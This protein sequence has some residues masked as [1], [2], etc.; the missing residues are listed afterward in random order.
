MLDD[1][2]SF[3]ARRPLFHHS[4]VAVFVKDNWVKHATLFIVHENPAMLEAK[5]DWEFLLQHLDDFL[6]ADL[7][8]VPINKRDDVTLKFLLL[9]TKDLVSKYCDAFASN[10]DQNIGH[11][12]VCMWPDRCPSSLE[13]LA[14]GS[15]RKQSFAL[16]YF[17]RWLWA[18]RKH[19]HLFLW[20]KLSSFSIDW[21]LRRRGLAI[22]L[23]LDSVQKHTHIKDRNRDHLRLEEGFPCL[24]NRRKT[25]L[26]LIFLGLEY[27]IN[28]LFVRKLHLLVRSGILFLAFKN[29]C[30]HVF[31]D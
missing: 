9:V 4:F 27:N 10:F 3:K 20:H 8:S 5:Q 31:I 21:L 26:A 18:H 30:L 23:N 7:A 16:S 29:K 22:I 24:P 6:Y 19:W 11:V 2:F 14:R 28:G 13:A 15:F 12:E 17:W 25:W 1:E